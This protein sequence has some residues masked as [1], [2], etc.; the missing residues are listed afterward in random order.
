MK[1][2]IGWKLISLALDRD[3]WELYLKFLSREIFIN[4]CWNY[5]KIHICKILKIWNLNHVTRTI[6]NGRAVYWS[7]V[8]ACIKLKLQ[9]AFSGINTFQIRKTTLSSTLFIRLWMKR[10]HCESLMPLLKLFFLSFLLGQSCNYVYYNI[11][12]Y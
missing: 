8:S 11:L 1:G 10:Y 2:G 5:T 4:L 6:T 7:R 3:P 9:L 12:I